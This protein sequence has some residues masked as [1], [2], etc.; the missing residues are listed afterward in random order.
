MGWLSAAQA[1]PLFANRWQCI[2]RCRC[3]F[4]PN[5][6]LPATSRRLR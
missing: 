4:P 5:W 3:K 2:R 6:R 1:L